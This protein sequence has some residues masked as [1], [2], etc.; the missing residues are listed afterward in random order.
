MRAD[1]QLFRMVKDRYS[2]WDSGVG[3][4]IE[5]GKH[6]FASLE[7]YM[8]RKREAAANKSGRQELFENVVNQYIF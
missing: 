3:A 5:A 6:D 2:S 1:G 8:L 7:K 4:E